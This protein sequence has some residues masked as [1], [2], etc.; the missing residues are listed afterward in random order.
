M[1]AGI[2]DMT[3]RSEL[4]QNLGM[5]T[6]K[7]IACFLVGFDTQSCCHWR[8]RITPAEHGEEG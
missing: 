5:L 2:R 8:M 6:T 7:G 4:S 1:H 3:V